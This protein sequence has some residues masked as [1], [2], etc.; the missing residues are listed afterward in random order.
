MGAVNRIGAALAATLML[1]APALWNRFPLL[2]Y[3]TG[4]Y[5]AR[6]FE[7]T[8]EESRSTVYGLTLDLLARPDFWPVVLIQAGL[9]VW[10]LA[11]V[12]RV[13]GFGTGA[14]VLLGTVLALSVFTALPWIVDV[15]LTDIFAGLG[16]LALYLLLL[17]REALARW[18]RVALFLVVSYAAATHS[19]TLLVLAALLAAGLLVAL[20]D[21]TRVSFTAIAR[22]VAALVLGAAM[23]VAANFAVSGRIAWTPGGAAI[24]FGRMLQAGIVTRYLDD[25]CPDPRLRLCDHRNELPKTADEFFWGGDLFNQLGRFQGLGDE[26]RTIVLESLVAYPRLQLEA[27]L[28]ATAEQLAKV[29]TGYGVST[30]IWH[31][32]AM[33]E[34]FVPGAVPGMR[35]ARQQHDELGFTAI[36]RVHLPVAWATALL[37]LGVIA[38]APTRARYGDLG[39]LA[40]TVAIAILANAVACGALSN[41]NDRYGARLAWLAPF[42]LVLVAVR[43]MGRREEVQ[44]GQVQR[45]TPV[46]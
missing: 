16:V 17:R 14:R 24:V 22:G 46:S 12:L 15:L 37:L 28:E 23:L 13:H 3:D 29:A 31:T 2:Q 30:E 44:S 27:A 8:L 5:L 41:P 20:F 10:I 40:A 45:L 26:M 36:N 25:H 21:R 33:I 11:L 7:H 4:G 18:E 32:Y 43:A 35:A 34:R 9:T 39:W 42:V 1:L 19:A 38:L 6:W